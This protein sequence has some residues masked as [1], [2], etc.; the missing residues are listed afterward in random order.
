MF[1]EMK[2]IKKEYGNFVANNGIDFSLK[3]GEVHAIVGENGAGKTTLM[4]ILY[5]MEKPT[6]GKIII[7]DKERY[8]KGPSDAIDY[9]IGMIHQHFMLFH[10]LT[11]AE[12]IVIGNEPC[13]SI[14]FDKEKSNKKI[15][16]LCEKYR[17]FVDPKMKISECSVGLQQKVEIL[18]VLYRDT[19]VIIMDEPTAALTPI[20]V[21]ELLETIKFLAGQGKS[22]I[23]ITHKLQEVMEV[24]DRITV[25]RNGVV[26]GTLDAKNTNVEELS[27][28]MVGRDLK[29]L[30]PNACTPGKTVLSIEN[31]FIKGN[32]G[33]PVID[34]LT[35]N[36]REGEIVGI[37]GVSGN[38]QSEL[39]QAI[40]GLKAVDSGSVCI[41]GKELRG[42]SVRSIREAG[43]AHIPE[44]RYQCGVAENGNLMDNILMSYQYLDPS[45]QKH[46][47]LNLK[48]IRSLAKEKI[49]S[50]KVKTDSEER[51]AGSLSGGNLQ[52]LIVAR[53]L[54]QETPF[55]IAAEPTRGVDIGSIQ[56]IH[57]E[58]LKR[59][60]S[61]SA[62]LLV[63]SELSEIITLSDRVLVMYEGKILGELS[64]E[65]ATKEEIGLLMAGGRK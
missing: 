37:A 58:L 47:I 51:K 6:S 46:G 23:L 50:Y 30:K 54:G 16:D 32:K 55:I 1:L 63:S 8:F 38:G 34:H 43:L 33:K 64:G 15:T 24:S 29:A 44:D 49:E 7:D 57:A 5:G 3:K 61:G 27:R 14:L 36:I 48:R 11:V 21:K 45:V 41:Y 10:S 12:N 4:K 39:I 28:L 53:E 42:R 20:G 19:Q 31:L 9:G 13:K 62:I 18:K 59:R 40:S 26:T 60:E 56:F 52:K 2:N 25:I 35:F 17:I 22:I 65:K